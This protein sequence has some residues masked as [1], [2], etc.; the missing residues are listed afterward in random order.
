[1]VDVQMIHDCDQINWTVAELADD[2]LTYN[3]YKHIKCQWLVL[4]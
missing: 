3:L 4:I 1:M 2:Q